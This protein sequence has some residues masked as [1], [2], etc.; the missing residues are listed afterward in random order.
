MNYKF[1]RIM[2]KVISIIEIDQYYVNNGNANSSNISK[3]DLNA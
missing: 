1:I 2:R 3:N